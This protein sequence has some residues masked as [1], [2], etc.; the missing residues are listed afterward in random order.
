MSRQSRTAFTLIELLVVIAI[1][2]LLISI[3]LPALSKAREEGKR[4]LCM[5]NMKEIGT[6]VFIYMQSNDNLP[7]TY[8]H[9]TNANGDMVFY[10]GVNIY[11]SYSW[12][13]MRAPMPWPGDESGDWAKVPPEFRPLNKIIAPDVQGNQ[14]VALLQCPGDRSAISP[15]VGQ[16]PDDPVIQQSRSSWQAYGN[17]Y[18]I[19]WFFLDHEP[20][21]F[22]VEN[23]FK[24]GKQVCNQVVGGSAAE[25]VLMWEN[26]VDQL[27]VGAEPTGGGH[28]GEGWHRRFSSHTFLFMD[29]HAEHRRYDTRYSSGTGWRITRERRH[30][31][32]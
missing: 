20:M 9:S 3:L 26:Q 7:W 19:N 10:P 32:H 21:P 24:V 4:A 18:S 31:D 17:S 15:T 28:L 12:G 23:L 2:A 1:I 11:S 14:N 13:G 8:I 27:F 6:A 22:T 30:H 25:F 29:N 16:S 5:N